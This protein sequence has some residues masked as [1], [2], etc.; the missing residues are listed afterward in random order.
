M[1]F[2]R[3]CGENQPN[4]QA[5][6]AHEN[7][8]CHVYRTRKDDILALQRGRFE[9]QPDANSFLAQVQ[10]MEEFSVVCFKIT[11]DFNDM[12]SKLTCL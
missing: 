3:H 2:C 12:E 11:N 7:T 9:R 5:L 1:I 6:N 4:A 8:Q 10:N